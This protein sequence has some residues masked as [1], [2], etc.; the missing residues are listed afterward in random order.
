MADEWRMIVAVSMVDGILFDKL[1]AIAKNLKAKTKSGG[2]DP[3]FG[4]I[5]VSHKSSSVIGPSL[6]WRVIDSSWS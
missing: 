5:Q 3:P 1:D 4:G 2:A 6:P